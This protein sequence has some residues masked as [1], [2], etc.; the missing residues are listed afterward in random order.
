VRKSAGTE[1]SEN[2]RE[3][4]DPIPGKF[5]QFL[6][7]PKATFLFLSK[8]LMAEEKVKKQEIENILSRI[9]SPGVVVYSIRLSHK[10]PNREIEIFLDQAG[11]LTLDACAEIHKNFARCSDGTSIDSYQVSFG[12]PGLDRDCIYPQDFQLH[13]GR[14]FF[15][16]LKD[17]REIS[18]KVE[19]DENS[20]TLRI[21]SQ[22]NEPVEIFW[23][24]VMVARFKF[25]A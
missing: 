9:L 17:D 24:D 13:Q 19:I 25:A 2:H 8:I 10:E 7:W 14:E 11:G 20:E 5:D 4:G 16:R 3:A 6:E 12:T 18:G 21:Q 15:I 22:D 1:W 23:K